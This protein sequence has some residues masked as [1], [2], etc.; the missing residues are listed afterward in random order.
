[1]EE[2]KISINQKVIIHKAKKTNTKFWQELEGK[3]ARVVSVH[4]RAAVVELD[5]DKQLFVVGI[6]DLQVENG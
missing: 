1:M 3:R 5:Q 6:K 2:V 4:T